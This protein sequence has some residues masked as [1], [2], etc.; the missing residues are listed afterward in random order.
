[1]ARDDQRRGLAVHICADVLTTE[2][3]RRWPPLVAARDTVQRAER[4]CQRAGIVEQRAL[5]GEA[6]TRDAM[7]GA[8]EAAAGSLAGDGVLVLTFS[9]HTERGDGPIDTTRWCFADGPLRVAE[10]AAR[11]AR[12]PST[13]R[14]IVIADTC[15]GAAIAHAPLGP[16]PLLLIAGCGDEQ[17]MVERANSEFVVR[18]EE[19]VGRC[20]GRSLAEVKV[21]LEADTP[22]SERPVVWTNTPAWWA[23]P[24]FEA[25]SS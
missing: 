21:V 22:D 3:Y 23:S 10:I 6:A 5:L 14:I 15:Y 1:V 19:L 12:L 11:L 8:L 20:A 7:L 18:L 13:A 2:P 24:I 25:G 9:G 16:Q 17:T 4:L